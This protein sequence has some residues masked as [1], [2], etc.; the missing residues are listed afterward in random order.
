M[1]YLL[2]ESGIFYSGKYNQFITDVFGVAIQQHNTSALGKGFNLQYT[3]HDGLSREVSI[4]KIV[5]YG[6]IFQGQNPFF[7]QFQYTVYDRKSTRLTSRHVA[8]SYA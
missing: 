3:R 6:H 5:I 1:H 7:F 4:K 2:T 8:I